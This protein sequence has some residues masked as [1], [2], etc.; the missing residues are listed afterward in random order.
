MIRRGPGRGKT[1]MRGLLEAIDKAG[2]VRALARQLGIAHQSI[3]SWD[4]V[5]AERVVVIW[6]LTGVPRQ[7]LR[8]DLYEGMRES[9]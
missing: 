1:D 3:A 8:P 2:G 4:K 9:A 6:R 7:R 5:P